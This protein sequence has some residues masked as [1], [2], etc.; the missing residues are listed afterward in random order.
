M[1]HIQAYSGFDRA[2]HKQLQ[3]EHTGVCNINLDIKVSDNQRVG[4][5]YDCR[6]YQA[7][8]TRRVKDGQIETR[9]HLCLTVTFNHDIVDGAPAARFLKRFSELLMTGELLLDEAD[10]ALES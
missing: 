10:V 2:L 7:A 9:E 8:K 6:C 4:N 1:V 3:I 5:F